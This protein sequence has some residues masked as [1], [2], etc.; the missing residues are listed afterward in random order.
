[1]IKDK[2][3]SSGHDISSGGL[4]TSLLEMCFPNNNI[5][6]D[7]DLK[8]FGE[9]DLIKVLFS[10]SLGLIFQAKSDVENIFEQH[11]IS[12]LKIGNTN[13]S[14]KLSFKSLNEEIILS[15]Q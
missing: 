12:F 15:S 7:I 3:I 8:L 1:M 13:N 11:D 6:A 2:L 4:V 5:G 10:E 14:S 9:K